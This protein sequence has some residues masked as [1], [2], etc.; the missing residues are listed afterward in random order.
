M[1]VRVLF[2]QEPDLRSASPAE[3]GTTLFELRILTLAPPTLADRPA[4]L[5]GTS[6]GVAVRIR[7]ETRV[8]LL[9]SGPPR[10]PPLPRPLPLG[11]QGLGVHR[12]PTPPFHTRWLDGRRRLWSRHESCNAQVRVPAA[13]C[14]PPASGQGTAGA[15]EWPPHHMRWTP[16]GTL[17]HSQRPS[18]FE[19]PPSSSTPL[20]QHRPRRE[21]SPAPGAPASPLAP[22]PPLP[23][24]AVLAPPLSPPPAPPPRPRLGRGV[25]AGHRQH[26]RGRGP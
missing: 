9:A 11:W 2:I 13:S 18:S 14:W 5:I 7:S 26:G 6:R 10:A 22:R 24:R 16:P 20:P 4:R 12:R 8:R 1:H 17:Y 3:L 25:H 21:S 19:P 23:P 15:G